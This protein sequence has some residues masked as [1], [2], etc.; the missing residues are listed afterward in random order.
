MNNITK[1][2]LL[3]PSVIVAMLLTPTNLTAQP[4]SLLNIVY[5]DKGGPDQTMYLF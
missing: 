2:T 3:L 4:Q 1:M 5:V